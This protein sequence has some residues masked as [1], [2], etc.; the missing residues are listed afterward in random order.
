M[1]THLFI[2]ASIAAM[3]IIF[4]GCCTTRTQSYSYKIWVP[5]YKS[6]DEIR[7]GVKTLSSQDFKNPGK[8]YTYGNYLFVNENRRRHTYNRQ[9]DHY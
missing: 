7:N 4:S 2:L 8:I 5:V 3:A 1:K 9:F 6:Y